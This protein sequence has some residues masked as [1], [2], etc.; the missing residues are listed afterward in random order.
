MIH[1][2]SLSRGS[3]LTEENLPRFQQEQSFMRDKWKD[4]LIYDPYFNPN[5]YYHT[6]STQYA[7]PPVIP[8]EWEEITMP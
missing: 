8:Y 7:F 6:T 5:L 2:E 1:Y 3:D 4:A